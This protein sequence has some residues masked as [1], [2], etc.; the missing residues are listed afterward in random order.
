MAYTEIA[1]NVTATTYDDTASSAAVTYR[2]R[3]SPDGGITWIYSNEAT[4]RDALYQDIVLELRV[5]N[6]ITTVG[7][8]TGG[9]KSNTSTARAAHAQATASG[10]GKAFASRT[11][12]AETRAIGVSSAGAAASQAQHL[13]AVTQGTACGSGVAAASAQ[14]FADWIAQTVVLDLWTPWASV[15]GG[16]VG[17]GGSRVRAVGHGAE[18]V[19]IATGL[20]SAKGELFELVDPSE[21]PRIRPRG[22][23]RIIRPKKSDDAVHVSEIG[24]V[25]PIRKDR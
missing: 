11:H 16:A 10:Q 23:V 6:D 25:R 20:G 14:P 18:L 13:E 15:S 5:S 22:G 17:G 4:V 9:G 8:S 24:P 12:H 19:G 21:L 7:T 3:V 1:S 2:Y